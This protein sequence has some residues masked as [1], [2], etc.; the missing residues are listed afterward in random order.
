MQSS[1]NKNINI[2]ATFNNIY[3]IVQHTLKGQSFFSFFYHLLL[4][5]Y[6]TFDVNGKIMHQVKNSCKNTNLFFV[7]KHIDCIFASGRS[8]NTDLQFIAIHIKTCKKRFMQLKDWSIL[9]Y[10]ED[11]LELKVRLYLTDFIFKTLN[12]QHLFI[13]NQK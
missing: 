7:K 8:G 4:L 12:T 13:S 11:I 1:L 10:S 2:T 3:V 9:S 5:Q 6:Q